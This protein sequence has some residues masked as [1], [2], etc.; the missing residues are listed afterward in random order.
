MAALTT[1]VIPAMIGYTTILA[2][3]KGM[4]ELFPLTV[5]V[6]LLAVFVMVDFAFRWNLATESDPD[7]SFFRAWLL[8]HYRDAGAIPT[9]VEVL[10]S[11]LMQFVQQWDSDE[12][13]HRIVPIRRWSKRFFI[14]GI[15][16]M[17]GT[18]TAYAVGIFRSGSIF[19]WTF[20][21]LFTALFVLGGLDMWYEEHRMP[22]LN[23]PM[24]SSLPKR[25]YGNNSMLDEEQLIA[26]HTSTMTIVLVRVSAQLMEILSAPFAWEL[27]DF[28]IAIY[29]LVG[30]CGVAWVGGLTSRNPYSPSILLG[31]AGLYLFEAIRSWRK[32][33]LQEALR[34]H[35]IYH[36][37][38]R[39]KKLEEILSLDD[40]LDIYYFSKED[41][42]PSEQR[43]AAKIVAVYAGLLR[44][45][46][47]MLPAEDPVTVNFK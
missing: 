34:M 3:I 24:R 31:T 44:K 33:G 22:I 42:T 2:I 12:Y 39:V 20:Y 15:L 38:S 43:V 35:Q 28:A 26:A 13:R 19:P 21:F 36:H 47:L 40:M 16:V 5:L 29:M 18:I 23:I 17:I 25:R 27:D 6:G 10:E 11:D 9:S 4:F 46:P 37:L 30:L 14:G 45:P 32:T 8:T 7:Y 1:F 41:S